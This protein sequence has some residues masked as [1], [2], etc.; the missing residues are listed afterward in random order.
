MDTEGATLETVDIDAKPEDVSNLGENRE[1]EIPAAA[2]ESEEEREHE[3]QKE[4]PITGSKDQKE[5]ATSETYLGNIPDNNSCSKVLS[6]ESEVMT[7][8]ISKTI[9]ENPAKDPTAYENIE[10]PKIPQTTEPMQEN[11]P[12][13][14]K[15]IFESGSVETGI[16][17]TKEVR[18]YQREDLCEHLELDNEKYISKPE[19]AEI[20]KK[21]E[22]RDAVD[23]GEV[24]KSKTLEDEESSNVGDETL[25]CTESI[26][27]DKKEAVQEEEEDSTKKFEASLT[28]GFAI[29]KAPFELEAG[30]HNQELEATNTK[31]HG[32]LTEEVRET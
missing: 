19:D 6:K 1:H 21:Q 29:E 16:E 20:S 15:E 31:N 23:Q 22:T 14:A 5:V 27:A 4:T 17:S 28:G 25:K 2:D 32:I 11:M 12:T 26:S 3:M 13:N 9:D 8:E 24:C 30:A 10:T 18:S 7:G